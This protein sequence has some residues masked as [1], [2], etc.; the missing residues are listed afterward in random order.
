MGVPSVVMVKREVGKVC[1]EADDVSVLDSLVGDWASLIEGSGA[2][3]ENFIKCVNF[4]IMKK[5]ISYVGKYLPFA[6]ITLKS[7]FGF[8]CVAGA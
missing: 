7:L 3:S 8:W 6:E 1:K 4:D 5:N 2:L